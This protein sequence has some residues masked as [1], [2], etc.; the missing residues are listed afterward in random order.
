MGIKLGS[1][2]MKSEKNILI[3]SCYFVVCL[4][5]PKMLD[6]THI[7]LLDISSVLENNEG[8]VKLLSLKK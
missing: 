7:R 6:H 2:E 8:E 4:L 1:T 5:Y 3:A